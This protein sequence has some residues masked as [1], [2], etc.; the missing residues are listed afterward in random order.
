VDS[1]TLK[2]LSALFDD[3]K[4]FP[5][6]AM[7][8][9]HTLSCVTLGASMTIAL[10]AASQD[11]DANDRRV[12]A[13]NLLTAVPIASPPQ[14]VPREARVNPFLGRTA[15][16]EELLLQLEEERIRTQIALERAQQTR[17]LRESQPSP[18]GSGVPVLGALPLGVGQPMAA[19]VATPAVVTP[20]REVTGARLRADLPLVQTPPVALPPPASSASAAVAPPPTPRLLGI[21]SAAPGGSRQA[22]V[23]FAGR[24]LMLSEG[25]QSA[26]VRIGLVSAR[27]AVLNGQFIAL[28][29]EPTRLR[30]PE[31]SAPPPA[32][33]PTAAVPSMPSVTG[34]IA[35]AANVTTHAVPTPHLDLALRP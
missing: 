15:R 14:E 27:G 19:S 10:V 1:F 8:R 24:I 23:A 34:Q 7:S 28:A 22:M 20:T 30:S 31:K 4:G 13:A 2:P 35:P 21:L 33:Q 5:M 11:L 16:N 12:R 9:I 32:V 25:E 26:G 3:F 6:F 29:D 18:M 17:A